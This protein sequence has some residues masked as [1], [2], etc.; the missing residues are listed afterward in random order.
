MSYNGG[1]NDNLSARQGPFQCC[2]LSGLACSILLI[3]GAFIVFSGCG[4]GGEDN[5]P[6]VPAMIT[7]PDVEER[8]ELEIEPDSSMPVPGMPLMPIV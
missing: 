1:M 7:V 6:P 5:D 8:E 3:G 4:G 2:N